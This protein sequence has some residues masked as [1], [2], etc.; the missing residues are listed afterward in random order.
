MPGVRVIVNSEVLFDGDLGSWSATAPD[1]VKNI[2]SSDVRPRPYFK[3]IG[4]MM[5]EA[6]MLGDSI[7]IEVIDRGQSRWD[8]AMAVASRDGV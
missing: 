6:V 7:Q 4:V 1:F 2:I 3:V 8:W 5:A